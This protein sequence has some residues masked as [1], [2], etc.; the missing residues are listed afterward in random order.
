VLDAANDDSVL[1]G[2][3]RL[4]DEHGA[5]DGLVVAAAP[6]ARTLDPARNS[7]PAQVL[8]AFQGKTLTF[9]RLANAVI[10][11]MVEAGYGRVVGISGQNA[12]RRATSPG[13]CATAR[14]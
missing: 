9:L 7:D 14:S 4:R 13:R 6:S 3:E 8:E 1:A 5:L 11:A 2:L 10:P 12:F